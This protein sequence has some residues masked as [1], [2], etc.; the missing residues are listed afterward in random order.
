MVHERYELP[1]QVAKVL[2][3]ERIERAVDRVHAVRARA[4]HDAVCW[5]E[6][7][8]VLALARV[9]ADGTRDLLL[10]RHELLADAALVEDRVEQVDHGVVRPED[11]VCRRRKR[12]HCAVERSVDVVV[13]ASLDRGRHVVDRLCGKE[14]VPHRRVAR[15]RWEELGVPRP[16][17]DAPHALAPS[18]VASVAK[19]VE[20][21][22]R[23]A[24]A[25]SLDAVDAQEDF[26]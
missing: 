10:E 22:R 17:R 9:P 19:V 15:G 8:A 16:A 3:N 4:H 20:W 11:R 13:H 12:R 7:R 14:L 6:L 24:V 23:G 25:S 26:L 18:G 5:T 1:R 21:V 2:A